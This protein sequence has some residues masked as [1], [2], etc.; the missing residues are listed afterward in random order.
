MIVI[1]GT[2]TVIAKGKKGIARL[3]AIAEENNEAPRMAAKGIFSE[4][5]FNRIAVEDI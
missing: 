5:Q 4:L 3:K 1:D 2:A